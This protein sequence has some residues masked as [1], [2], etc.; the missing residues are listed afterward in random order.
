MLGQGVPR[1]FE[2]A[3][4]WLAPAANRGHPYA[5]FLLAKMLEEGEGGP[6]DAASAAKYYEPAANYGIAEA[7]YRLG[8]LT[9]AGPS[10][11]DAVLAFPAALQGLEPVSR[12]N[13]KVAQRQGRF[14]PVQLQSKS[15]IFAEHPPGGGDGQRVRCSRRL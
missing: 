2:E 8:L 7:Q 3:R 1:N 12:Q 9:F 13:G 6:V 11:A 15:Q 10:D 14:E 4:R 5:Q